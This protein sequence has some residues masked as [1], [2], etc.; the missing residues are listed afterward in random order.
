MQ[1]DHS[2]AVVGDILGVWGGSRKTPQCLQG[3]KLY[4]I[5]TLRE[6]WNLDKLKKIQK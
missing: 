5:A 6:G 4:K 3:R 1:I 2:I